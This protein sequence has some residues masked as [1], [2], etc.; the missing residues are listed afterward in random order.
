MKCKEVCI[1]RL[2][3]DAA[4]KVDSGCGKGGKGRGGGLGGGM[5]GSAIISEWNAQVHPDLRSL[6]TY[7]NQFYTH[8]P[9][10]DRAD[11]TQIQSVYYNDLFTPISNTLPQRMFSITSFNCDI[12]FETNSFWYKTY[13]DIRSYVRPGQ[14]FSWRSLRSCNFHL[15]LTG[16]IVLLRYLHTLRRTKLSLA[17]PLTVAWLSKSFRNAVI[18]LPIV[19]HDT[20]CH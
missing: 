8:P 16:M 11:Q 19:I 2:A 12:V 3:R 20:R 13:M 7:A 18:A 10:I 9:L 5:K 17:G 1:W 6:V 4:P 15:P 14:L